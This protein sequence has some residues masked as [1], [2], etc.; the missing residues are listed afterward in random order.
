[1][2]KVIVEINDLLV[3]QLYKIRDTMPMLVHV[4]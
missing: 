2:T 3:D 4:S 1:V